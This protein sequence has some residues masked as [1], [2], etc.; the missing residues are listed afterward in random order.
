MIVQRIMRCVLVVALWLPLLAVGQVGASP[1]QLQVC[2]QPARLTVG[3]TGRV[4]TVPSLPNRVRSYPG[5]N[6]P[7]TGQIPAG[8]VF[9]VT[10]GPFCEAGILWW[11]VNYSGGLGWTAEGD[12]FTYW[13]EP[14]GNVPPPPPPPPPPACALAT[15]LTIGGQGRVTPGLPNLLRSAPGTA[16]NSQVIGQIPGGGQFAV[17][18]G[19]Q[20]GND[21]RWWWQVN[22][23]GLI[24]W[25]AE[26]EGTNTYWTEPIYSG[27]L[28]CPGFLPSRLT[29]GATGRVTTVPNLPNRIRANPGFNANVLGQIPAG[30]QFWIA[31]GPF[32]AENTAW[33]Q[34]SYAGIVG[35]TAEGQA[36]TYWLQPIAQT[37]QC[38][39]SPA[40][41]L[42]GLVQGRVSPGTGSSIRLTPESGTV[43]ATMPAG[44]VF[45][46]LFGPICGPSSQQ[47]TWYQVEYNGTVGWT[48]EGRGGVYW[49]EPP[50][51]G[52]PR[53]CA[54]SPPTRLI[55][56]TQARV[57]IGGGPNSIRNGI[58]SG[59]V[60]GHI[61]EG[62]TFRIVGGPVC[63]PSSFHQTWYQVEY[64][65]I[66]GWTVEGWQNEYYLQP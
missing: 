59:V 21:G 57:T 2:N 22:Y 39:G 29:A 14:A 9:T 66:T 24:G 44:A 52:G 20:C 63:G 49:L 27:P 6:A 23:Q 48:A 51:G 56:L 18:S 12:G 61:P 50:V 40:S 32:C 11:Q 28:S 38:A 60:L 47:L 13:L 64:N 30:E 65:G 62:A 45:N 26:G 4:T 31:N 25:T 5:F 55:G 7:V 43:L 33:W 58:E 16:S 42:V 17:L 54:G 41:R 36:N 35:W 34:V 19:P 15:R 3:G 53:L 8:G 10:G 1:A 46:I 37:G